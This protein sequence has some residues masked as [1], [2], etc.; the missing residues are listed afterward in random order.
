MTVTAH[1]A[2]THD[3]DEGECA[4]CDDTCGDCFGRMSAPADHCDYCG[5]C[6]SDGLGRCDECDAAEIAEDD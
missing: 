3:A 6:I 4:I 1:D 2:R 5:A